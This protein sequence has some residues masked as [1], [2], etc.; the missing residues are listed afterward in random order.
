MASAN[1]KRIW[2]WMFF[3]WATQP[4]YT[5]GL[6]FIFGP[7][8]AAVATGY[9]AGTGL[10]EAT[11][12]AQAQSLWSLGQTLAGLLIAFTAPFIGAYA[13]QT[14]RRMPWIWVFSAIYVVMAALLWQTMP[15]GSTMWTMLLVF[16]V[17]F[18]AAEYLLIFVNA[19]LPSLGNDK[20]V[21]RISGSGAALGYWGGV[22]SLFI[23]LIFLAESE[24][25]KTLVGMDPAFGLDA[26]AREGTRSVGPFIALWFVVF[27]VPFFAWVRED[28]PDANAP[29]AS[30]MKAFDDVVSTVL[31][32]PERKSLFAF[33]GASMFYR[34]ALNA[35]YGFGGVYATL[36]LN[37]SITMVGLFGIVGAITAAVA[38]WV[39]GLCDSRFG[40]KPVIRV[41]VWLLIVVCTVIVSM[42]REE[43]FGIAL[44]NDIP[45]PAALAPMIGATLGTADIIF[46]ILGAAI[47]GTGG[48]LYAASR[49][50]M[51]RHTNPDK[52]NEAF[53]LFAL[54]GKATAF[55]AP[56]LIGIFTASLNSAR[57]GV[58]PLIL[59][60]ILGLILLR[61]VNK[62][63]DRAE[64]S[65]SQS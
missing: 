27:M 13:D 20:E 19:M 4:F 47:G 23:M 37:W 29:K 40:P 58:S 6:T 18:V 5:L 30:V 41:C 44:R 34:D 22:L 32:L 8:F 31:S 43:L 50:M 1:K 53:G 7:Y 59:L 52:P 24:T 2:G 51:V 15:D 33:L 28:K 38:T 42:T 36:V 49:S 54:S 17:G 12:D 45:T 55:L 46:Y 26:E 48:A 64:W 39:G 61:W 21:G 16:S 65:G 14:G 63:G 25:G 3:D 57:L 10:D 60:F 9:F 56:G 35:L 62:E 11:A